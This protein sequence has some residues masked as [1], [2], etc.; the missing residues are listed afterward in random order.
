MSKHKAANKKPQRAA[1][2]PS[3]GLGRELPST[4]AQAQALWH[5][6]GHMAQAK[7][8]AGALNLYRQ[9]YA[10]LAEPGILLDVARAHLALGAFEPAAAAARE[11]RSALPMALAA[12]LMEAH[13][14]TQLKRYRLALEALVALPAQVPRESAYWQALT[15]AL[16]RC[17]L[18]QQ[19]IGPY[20]QWLA[21]D[22]ANPV[23]HFRL[24]KAFKRSHKKAEAAECF[25]TAL[26]LGIGSAM[27][28]RAI[29]V[30]LEAETC[31][32]VECREQL[33]LLRDDLWRLPRGEPCETNPFVNVVLSDDPME[34]RKIAEHRA[35]YLAKGI[36]ALPARRLAPRGAAS[37]GGERLRVGYLSCD[38]HNH[39]TALLMVNML[40]HHDRE[41]FDIT[42]LSTGRDDGS[43]MRQRVR[44]A[45]ERFE[46]LRG[47][48]EA[49]IA[50]RV[51]ELQIDVLV[52]LKGYTEG[53]QLKVFAYRSAPIQVAW[54]GYPGTTGADYIDYIIG[55]PVVTP[56]EHADHFS[57]K[58]AQMP[59][60]YQPNDAQR[61][62][63][64][65][66]SRA[67]WGLPEDALVLCAFHS[68]YKITE[69]V[70]D[71]WCSI[72][73]AMPHAVL[74]L[75][76]WN[77]SVE[78]I[79]RREAQAR[80]IAPD[81]LVFAD[82][83]SPNKNLSRLTC[84]DV[85]LDAWP[86][87]A[88]TTAGEAL[89]AGLPVVTLQGPSFA[90]RV[91]SSLL[92]AVGLPELVCTDALDY[93]ERVLALSFDAPARAALRQHLHAQRLDSPLFNGQRFAADIE[94]LYS[95]MWARHTQRLAPDHLPAL[96]VSR[97]RA[98]PVFAVDE[99]W[100]CVP[101]EN[102]QNAPHGSDGLLADALARAQAG[103]AAALALMQTQPGVGL[104][105]VYAS[106]L[107]EI[108]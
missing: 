34:Q 20:L 97:P 63:P 99:P 87:N 64:G 101:I 58:I 106:V 81:Q 70:F 2:A 92:H 9:A 30:L 56:L 12:Y 75:L 1:E 4:A 80:G 76:R 82:L 66:E 22:A 29:L 47:A 73:R 7:N 10:V 91:A 43:S 25:K 50:Q 61:A 105:P 53:S 55:D 78:V 83:V 19:A 85:F 84:A 26:A 32:W 60:C 41:R 77:A 95:R 98:T 8:W 108:P 21:S 17:D 48:S 18:W 104:R 71:T 57:E 3:A 67:A 40:E 33:N 103:D 27:S 107:K 94:L 90:Q 42:L 15:E 23:L 49:Q 39:A 51:R 65:L 102:P 89:W 100:P 46:D 45:S 37:G 14:H 31:D 88:H 59:V 38:F 52:D 86:C 62:L 44:A 5:Q 72:L 28:V 79:L 35:R 16:E 6:G 24:G 69:A 54:L 11:A 74:W 96:P 93:R 36:S 13:A 68:P